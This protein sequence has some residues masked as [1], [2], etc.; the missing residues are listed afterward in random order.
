MQ[1][2]WPYLFPLDIMTF[3]VAYTWTR[4]LVQHLSCR[5]AAQSYCQCYRVIN[6][7][8]YAQRNYGCLVCR[9][10]CT[11]FACGSSHASTIN[12]RSL[13]VDDGVFLLKPEAKVQFLHPWMSSFMCKV[14]EDASGFQGGRVSQNGKTHPAI[15]LGL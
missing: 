8:N 9:Q 7:D 3:G 2:E 4:A 15:E 10:A 5:G 12:T 13:S 1:T 11:K 14:R 6:I